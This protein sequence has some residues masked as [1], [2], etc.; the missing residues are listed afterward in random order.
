MNNENL[1][2]HFKVKDF[3]AWQ[4]SYNG[5]EKNRVGDILEEQ[6]IIGVVGAAKHF[7][8]RDTGDVREHRGMGLNRR[9]I[10]DHG[11]QAAE[12]E[13]AARRATDAQVLEDAERLIAAWNER[14]AVFTND[15]PKA[16]TWYRC[17]KMYSSALGQSP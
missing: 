1:T 16:R 14:Q 5:N 15:V 6:H 17:G 12:K 7:A 2:L 9:K 3:N 4:T 11:R 10:E 13:A 8:F